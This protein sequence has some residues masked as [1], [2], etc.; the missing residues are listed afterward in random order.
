MAPES[1]GDLHDAAEIDEILTLRT[2]LLTDEEKREARATDRRAARILDRVETMPPEVFSRLHGA[3]R[4][5]D[6]AGPPP[7]DSPDPRPVWW[8]EGADEGLSPATDAVPVGGVPVRSGSRVRLR[9]RGRGADAQDMFLAGHPVHGPR[10]PPGEQGPLPPPA[11]APQGRHRRRAAVHRDP[12]EAAR[13]A[14]EGHAEPVSRLSPPSTVRPERHTRKQEADMTAKRI[15]MAEAALVGGAL[16]ALLVK[17]WPGM[18]RE[19]R[20]W[21]MAGSRPR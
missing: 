8:R 5:L 15:L 20:I 7:G 12:L 14:H 19:V 1:P 2:L 4:S 21:R 11:R 18:R 3:I 16:L 10:H 13:R 6:P 17:E 9:P